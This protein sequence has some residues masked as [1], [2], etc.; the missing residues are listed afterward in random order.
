MSLNGPMKLWQDEWLC[1]SKCVHAYSKWILCAH[2]CCVSQWM[3]YFFVQY[4]CWFKWAL[5]C[6]FHS[7]SQISFILSFTTPCIGFVLQ[8]WKPLPLWCTRKKNLNT[9]G[10]LV[11]QYWTYD[12]KVAG[13]RSSGRNFFSRVNFSI[14]STPVTAVACK[15]FQSCCQKCRWQVTA[16]HTCTYICHFKWCMVVWCTQNVCWKVSHGTGTV[17]T[18]LWW[19]FNKNV[20][21]KAS[22]SFSCILQEHSGSAQK[23]TVVLFCC[24]TKM[25]RLT[26][27][28]D[29]FYPGPFPSVLPPFKWQSCICCRPRGCRWK[30]CSK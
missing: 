22:H 18:P 14:H 7:I 10:A 6:N 2:L 13:S 28:N 27:V 3:W 4:V 21:C 17:S 20:L 16:K 29:L 24:Y 23:Q 1:T 26:N 25:R 11:A 19:I 15:R 9:S 8:S 12:W 5:A 30:G